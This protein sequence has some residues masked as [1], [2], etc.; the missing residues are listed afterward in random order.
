MADQVCKLD[1]PAIVRVFISA[2]LMGAGSTALPFSVRAEASTN[3]VSLQSE[4]CREALQPKPLHG[5]H[6]PV[7]SADIAG[8]RDVGGPD[9]YQSH[10]RPFG[11]SPDGKWVAFMLRR[12]MPSFNAFCVGLVVVSLDNPQSGA[13]LLNVGGELIRRKSSQFRLVNMPSGL[14]RVS[15]PIWS[16]DGSRIAF[17][18]QDGGDLRIWV[19]ELKSGSVAPASPSGFE[20]VSFAW[21]SGSDRLSVIGAPRRSGT[22]EGDKEGQSGYHFDGR[23][24]PL[25]YSVPQEADP[26]RTSEIVVD[27]PAEGASKA[28]RAKPSATP[29]PV[30]ERQ[31]REREVSVDRTVWLAPAKPELLRSPNLLHARFQGSDFVCR[32]VACSNVSEFWLSQDHRSVFF[33]AIREP[34]RSIFGLYRWSPIDGAVTVLVET[35]D[36]VSGCAAAPSALICEREGSTSPR[37]VVSISTVDGRTSTLF[38][39]NPEFALLDLAPAKRLFWENRFGVRTFGDLVLPQHADARHRPPLVVVQYD[40]RGFLR[41]GTGDEYPIQPLVARG[42]AVLSFSRPLDYAASRSPLGI[43]KQ[44]KSSLTNWHDRRSIDSSLSAIVKTLIK[45]GFVDPNRIA[46]TGLSDGASTAGFA[47]IN[48]RL[49]SAA[50][51]STCCDDPIVQL[52][53]MGDGYGAFLSSLGFPASEKTWAPVSLRM[54]ASRVKVPILVQAADS[55]FRLALPTY[56]SLKRAGADIDMY[57]FP[58]EYHIKW[59]PAHRLAIYN[60]VIAWLEAWANA[61]PRHPR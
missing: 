38:E 20:P 34:A 41:G 49:F 39:P 36:I 43:S 26:I 30:T 61:P 29:L 60:R 10:A 50:V 9:D 47:L 14:P 44:D 23:F 12:G 45:A 52:G 19:A 55:E 15:A 51:L 54:N 31:P 40:S 7:T 6:R 21:S 57:V 37:S 18:R 22:D 27:V 3:S 25:S 33:L 53:M 58:D 13:R 46:I 11:I 32:Q 17:L 35:P 24:W 8:L 16:P 48:S 4:T 28:L 59:Q 1:R 42:F 2:M 56:E 5:P